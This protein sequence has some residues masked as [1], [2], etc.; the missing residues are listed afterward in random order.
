M[1]DLQTVKILLVEDNPGDIRLTQE[2]LKDGKLRNELSIVMDGEEAMLFL[3]KEGKYSDAITPDLILL[4]LN[5]PKKDGHEVLIEIKGD[6]QLS[7]IP[8]IIL[9]TSA[10]EKDIMNTYSNHANCYITK[11]VDLNQFTTVIRAIED[12]WLTIVKLPKK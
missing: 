3:K 2:V 11:P 8:V 9:T 1:N 6:P 10:A 7:L 12:F 4:D 5:L